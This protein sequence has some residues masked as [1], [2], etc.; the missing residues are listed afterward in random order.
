M[1]EA[2]DVDNNGEIDFSEF[3]MIISRRVDPHY[4]SDQVKA[5]FKVFEEKS[6]IKTPQSTI[7]AKELFTFLVKNSK[8]DIGEE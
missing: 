8:A 6:K 3:A 7:D 2:V 4:S 1:V 5:A